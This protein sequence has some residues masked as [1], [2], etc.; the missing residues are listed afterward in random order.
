MDRL[1]RQKINALIFATKR[2][3]A[4]KND[5]EIKALRAAVAEAD[6]F[7]RANQEKSREAINKYT[8][9]P[10]PILNSLPLPAVDPELRKAD[11]DLWAEMMERL[12]MLQGKPDTAKLIWH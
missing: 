1:P 2:D 5:G 10:L 3:W 8:H 9:V 11:L 4:A 7:I 12:H 6:E